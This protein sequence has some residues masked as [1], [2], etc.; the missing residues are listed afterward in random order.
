M[1][2]EMEGKSRNPTTLCS[3]FA[4]F[5]KLLPLSTLNLSAVITEVDAC[6]LCK[7]VIHDVLAPKH[8]TSGL[9]L[10]G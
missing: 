2:L 5:W 9:P 6:S 8:R 4:L 1:D 3:P 10:I 7:S